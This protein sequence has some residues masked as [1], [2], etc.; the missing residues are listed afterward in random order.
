MGDCW[1]CDGSSPRPQGQLTTPPSPD[2]GPC[3]RPRARG[4]GYEP[5]QRQR[6][7]KALPKVQVRKCP[8]RRRGGVPT[9]WF[10]L[11]SD[12]Q[13]SPSTRCAEPGSGPPPASPCPP[14]RRGVFRRPWTLRCGRRRG[15]DE[16]RRCGPG[17]RAVPARDTAG[18]AA[19][20]RRAPAGRRHGRGGDRVTELSGVDLTHQA[21]IAAREATKKSGAT[22]PR[23]G[24]E[25]SRPPRARV[26]GGGTPPRRRGARLSV[27]LAKAGQAPFSRTGVTISS[28]SQRAALSG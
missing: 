27:S 7:H 24:G 10:L 3:C 11:M 26:R 16:G 5:H 28:T 18:A 22:D 12:R 15:R 2:R 1:K 17:A 4:D 13:S 8:P 21:L 20:T 25:L 14:H 6:E 9:I 19:R 23:V